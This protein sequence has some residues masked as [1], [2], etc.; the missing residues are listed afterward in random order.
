[1]SD[2]YT[3]VL[4]RDN[5]RDAAIN[6]SQTG[7]VAKAFW[8]PRAKIEFKQTGRFF[9]ERIGAPKLAVVEVTVPDWL[10]RNEGLLA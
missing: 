5:A 4:H 9:Q 10:A 1:M 2:I 6:V 3:L 8:L 7:S